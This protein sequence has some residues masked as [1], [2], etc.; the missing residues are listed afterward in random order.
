MGVVE[1]WD[2]LKQHVEAEF[3]SV[4][5]RVEQDLPVID[6]AVLDAANSPVTA[7]LSAAVH[8]SEAPEVLAMIAD[9]ITKTDAALGAA[10]AAGAAEAG[11]PPA[12]AAPADPA[13][14]PAA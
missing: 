8:L 12:E 4:K 13:P 11:Q 14:V 6:K 5:A 9:F 1:S 10:K 2:N 3:A 7:A